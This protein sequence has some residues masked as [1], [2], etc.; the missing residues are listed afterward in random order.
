MKLLLSVLLFIT[1]G[2]AQATGLDAD[3]S[4]LAQAW[5]QANFTYDGDNREK[6][7]SALAEKAEALSADWPN[8]AE[9]LVWEGIV[10]ASWAGAKGGLGALGLVDRAR[11]RLLEAER[12]ERQG[13]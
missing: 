8:R 10:L 7:L 6:A 2:L 11:E 13:P 3:L 9:P 5:D 1:A 12:L 4:Q